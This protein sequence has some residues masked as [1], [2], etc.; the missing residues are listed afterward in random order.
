LN[1]LD[2]LIMSVLAFSAFHGLRCGFISSAAKLAGILLGFGVGITYYR[3]L[4]VYLNK[5]WNIEDKITPLTGKILKFFFPVKLTSAPSFHAGSTGSPGGL[6]AGQLNPYSLL[7]PDS[8]YLA[9]SFAMVILNAI[10]FLGLILITAQ[11]VR[12]AGHL[13]SRLADI[14]FLGPL[15]RI[16][17]LLFGGARGVIIVMVFLTLLAPFQQNGLAPKNDTIS[18]GTAP[19]AEAGAFSKSKIL[20]YFVPVFNA[21]DRPL[22]GVTPLIKNQVNPVQSV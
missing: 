22:P 15:N 13:F 20:P 17:G 21:I 10:C 6:T 1:W 7:N 11:A 3:D 4:A 12:L 2:W 14:S 18:P 16:G 19:N 8:E 9:R 5:L